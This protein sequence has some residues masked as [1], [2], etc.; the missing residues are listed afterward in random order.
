[1]VAHP[2]LNLGETDVEA[3]AREGLD[4]I[5]VWHPKQTAQQ[6]LR[7]EEI[8]RGL[9]VIASGGS[10]YHGPGRSRHEM[11]SSGVSLATLEKL[12]ERA[13]QARM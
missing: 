9:G 10:D 12:R 11:G 1:M 6:R 4:G 2:A 5:E 3:L 7:L 13:V 8:A